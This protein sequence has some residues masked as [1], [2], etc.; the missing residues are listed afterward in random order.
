VYLRHYVSLCKVKE[1]TRKEDVVAQ[2]FSEE[3]LPF[4]VE[5]VFSEELLPFLESAISTL[6]NDVTIRQGLYQG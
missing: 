4:P 3:L 6:Y 1:C 2:V 5:Q